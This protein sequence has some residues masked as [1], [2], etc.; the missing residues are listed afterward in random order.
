M[1]KVSERA[2]FKVIIGRPW[3]KAV[4]GIV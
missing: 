4:R 3:L 2:S 1:D